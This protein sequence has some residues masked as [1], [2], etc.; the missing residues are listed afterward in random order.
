MVSQSVETEHLS[1][2]A[3]AAHRGG[4]ALVSAVGPCHHSR[5][6]LPEHLTLIAEPAPCPGAAL[7]LSPPQGNRS[8][9]SSEC[10]FIIHSLQSA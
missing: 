4:A 8:Q 5:P 1:V 2:K 7:L 10:V 3:G 9:A 6:S